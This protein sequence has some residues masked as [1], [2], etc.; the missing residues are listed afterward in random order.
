MDIGLNQVLIREIAKD[1]TKAE[2][3]FHNTLFIKLVFSFITYFVVFLSVNLLGYPEITKKLV[4]LAALVIILDN[5]T[6]TICAVLRGFQNLKY[7]GIG[8]ILYELIVL[9]TGLVILFLHLPLYFIIFPLIFASASFLFFTSYF[10]IKK[11]QI[12]FAFKFKLSLIKNLIKNTLPFFIIGLFGV[13]FSYIDVVLL[14][15]LA[16]DKFVGFYSAAGKIPAGFRILPIAFSAALYPAASFYFEKDREGLKRIVE[17][18]I[19]Y[20]ILL[21]LPII[22]GLCI[23]ADQAITIIYGQNFLAAVPA[24]RILSWS[25][26]FVFLDYI[27]FTVLN[28]CG[29]EKQNVF[30]RGIVMIT[31]IILNLIMIPLWQHLGSA[32]AF[33]LSFILLSFLGASLT[34]RIIHFSLKRTIIYFLKVLFVSLIMGIV[35]LLLKTTVPLILLILIGAIIYLAGLLILGVVGKEDA[36]YLKSLLGFIKIHR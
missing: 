4:Y 33:T 17:K 19:F 5:F 25:I 8:L 6:N 34:Y 20:L 1:K 16:G 35:V 32:L 10:L 22:V 26:F 2:S 14:S 31:I 12:S 23:L 9:I 28:A 7:E 27:F 29:K 36:Q 30:N 24:L 15:K 21:S 3:Y 11:Y 13:I 18:A